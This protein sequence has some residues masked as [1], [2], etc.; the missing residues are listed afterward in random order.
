MTASKLPNIDF[1]KTNKKIIDTI[2]NIKN[3]FTTKGYIPT[4]TSLIED[5]DIFTRKSGVRLSSKLYSF[6]D[7]GGRSVSLRPEF[8]TSIIKNFLKTYEPD[9]LPLKFQYN[10]P[11]FAYNPNQID[12]LE[13]RN[14]IG[15]ELIG[16]NGLEIDSDI[17]YMSIKALELIG[18]DK[19]KIKIGNLE[20][21]N[22]ILTVF[23][24]SNPAI[25]LILNNLQSIQSNKITTEDIIYKAEK[26]GI[27]NNTKNNPQNTP[28]KENKLDFS[29]IVLK[30]HLN[31]TVGQRSPDDI[32]KRLFKKRKY[33]DN[34]QALKDAIFLTKSLVKID[35]PPEK[36]L[37]ETRKILQENSIPEK[38]L[39]PLE[40]ISNSIEKTIGPNA[41]INLVPAH[42][43][44]LEYYTGII[45][46]INYQNKSELIHLGGGGRYD[47]LVQIL[48][49][50][51]MV[52]A[53]GFAYS[54]EN[55][56]KVLE[57]INGK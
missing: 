19:T 18:M 15:I 36:A 22:K 24:L 47:E 23:E 42:I 5:S 13:Q 2:D 32:I 52:P 38:L 16:Q 11:V 7:P 55:I 31:S 25:N 14:Q 49:G 45:F 54:L 46:D 26:L 53:L 40:E 51:E 34:S 30:E 10:G 29:D 9:D 3:F 6:V 35:A 4:S 48:G 41:N 20:F 21:L 28:N 17:L 56:Q 1:D 50:R 43:R 8:T 39:I 12:G 27:F 37:N 33:S 57:I 44:G